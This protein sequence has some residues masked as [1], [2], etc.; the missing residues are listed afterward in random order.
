[1]HRTS[2]KPMAPATKVSAGQTL[3]AQLFDDLSKPETGLIARL[4]QNAETQ[5]S[6]TGTA[7]GGTTSKAVLRDALLLELKGLNRTA[8]AMAAAKGKPEIMDKFRMPT[9][10]SDT[11]LVAKAR[12]I[13]DAASPMA[14]D[15]VL[16][17]H[18]TTLA[19]DLRAQIE[20]FNNADATQSTG[21]QTQAGATEGFNPLLQEGMTKSKQLDAIMHNLYRSNAQ[22]LGEWRTASHVERQ[23]NK[24]ETPN[25]PTPPKP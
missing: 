11:V 8:S 23:A 3:A 19:D 2:N 18:E 24:K 17:G 15:F 12:A 4:A 7:R 10:V 9:G 6:G 1:M 13:V 5:Q 22:K 20:A 16:Y 21:E 25:T 14:A